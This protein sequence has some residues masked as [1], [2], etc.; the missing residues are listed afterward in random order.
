MNIEINNSNDINDLENT[1][2]EEKTV[3]RDPLVAR[4]ILP[5]SRG[6]L[7]EIKSRLSSDKWQSISFE[8]N[9]VLP[10]S[11]SPLHLAPLNTVGCV[12]I[13]S[14]IFNNRSTGMPVLNVL[15]YSDTELFSLNEHTLRIPSQTG[16][17]LFVTG[18][19]SRLGLE[20]SDHLPDCPLELNI[21]I[22]IKTGLFLHERA[23]RAHLELDDWETILESR[24]NDSN[25][26]YNLHVGIARVAMDRGDWTEAV[27]R[28]QDVVSIKGSR[29]PSYVYKN[30]NKAY[31]E[32]ESFPAGNPEEEKTSG[33]VDKHRLLSMA[34]EKIKPRKYLE[35]GVHRGRSLALAKCEAI[36]VDPMPMLEGPLPEH[37]RVV[38]M[39]S[40]EYF[41]SPAQEDLKPGPDLIFIDG[42][43]LF[44]YALRDFINAERFAFPWTLIVIDDIFPVHPVQAERRRR[45]RTWTGDVWKLYETLRNHRPDLFLLPVDASPTGILFISALNPDNAELSSNYD[46]IAREYAHDTSPPDHILTRLD[47]R[48]VDDTTIA[49]FFNIL[50]NARH[51]N[52][53][54]NTISQQLTLEVNP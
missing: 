30:L 45:T 37:S 16:L 8:I 46:D 39:T 33:K 25:I 27:R 7:S 50:I 22:M 35:I 41:A 17:N 48:S 6:K 1:L 28:W 23:I 34:H 20:V 19:D 43:H 12:S 14:I 13:S 53:D 15:E 47:T 42:M 49:G 4:L 36:G 24:K 52:L 51:N 44:E 54:S 18:P 9:T 11:I 32:L 29:T 3:H 2:T 31:L 5:D 40:D 21:N 10:L 38:T 26:E